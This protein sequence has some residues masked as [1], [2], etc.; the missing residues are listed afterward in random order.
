[1]GVSGRKADFVPFFSCLVS[2]SDNTVLKV[3]NRWNERLNR[4]VEMVE[5]C[6]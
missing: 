4:A 5:T 1:M 6:F 3:W 2:D